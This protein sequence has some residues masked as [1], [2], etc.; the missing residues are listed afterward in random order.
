MPVEPNGEGGDIGDA[1]SRRFQDVLP[2][3]TQSLDFAAVYVTAA[4]RLAIISQPS[5]STNPH[6]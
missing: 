6:P 3:C 5:K 2:V 4:L 1:R